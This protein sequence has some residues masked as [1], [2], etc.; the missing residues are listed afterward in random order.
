MSDSGEHTFSMILIA[1]VS[2]FHAVLVTTY[3]YIY[4]YIYNPSSS[5]S[6]YTYIKKTVRFLAVKFLI[7]I[8]PIG[9]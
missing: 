5:S 7:Q 4:I 2:L 6:I 3:I 8:H 1:S 9:R